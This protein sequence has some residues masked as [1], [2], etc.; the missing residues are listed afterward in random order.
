[1]AVWSWVAAVGSRFWVAFQRTVNEHVINLPLTLL[2]YPCKSIYT[3][4]FWEFS[5][6]G[7]GF[8]LTGWSSTVPII[9]YRSN[10]NQITCVIAV[11]NYTGACFKLFD[12]YSHKYNPFLYLVL[13]LIQFPYLLI[14]PTTIYKEKHYSFDESWKLFLFRSL[15]FF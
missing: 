3:C 6:N 1:M 10:C 14:L 11:N 5:T 12:M 2:I 13:F 9:N 8:F 15:R 4:L 7:K